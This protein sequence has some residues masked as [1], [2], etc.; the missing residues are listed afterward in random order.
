M[1]FNTKILDERAHIFK[2]QID[3]SIKG[4]YHGKT[5]LLSM[6]CTIIL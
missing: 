2:S 5:T 4:K 3:F 1:G 6:K